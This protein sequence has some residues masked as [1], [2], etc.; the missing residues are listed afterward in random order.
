MAASGAPLCLLLLPKDVSCDSEGSWQGTQGSQR[1]GCSWSHGFAVTDSLAWEPGA[2]PTSRRSTRD[3][4]L[5]RGCV[6][7]EPRLRSHFH[8]N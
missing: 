1:L 4:L 6:F 3:V 5:A 2:A 8:A 7:C